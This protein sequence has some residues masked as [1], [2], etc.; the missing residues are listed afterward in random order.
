SG[1]AAAAQGRPAGTAGFDL[2]QLAG[3]PMETAIDAIVDR[4]CPPGILDEELV[5]AAITEALIESLDGADLFDPSAIDDRTVVVATVCFVAELVFA[6]VMA[7]QG[8]SA[9]QVDPLMAV[10]R[11][12]ALRDLVREVA[13]HVATP[14]LQRNGGALEPAQI[15]SIIVEITSTVYGEI[16]EW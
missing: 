16:A 7:E 12:N 3:L 10:Q 4:F 5:R 15:E 2:G 6:S 14:I 13:D 9:D 1:F 8:R 11:E